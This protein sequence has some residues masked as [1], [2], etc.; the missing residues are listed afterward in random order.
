MDGWREG[1][2]EGW[3]EH[4]PCG[5]PVPCDREIQSPVFNPLK[6]DHHSHFTDN[7]TETG[8][9]KSLA[10]SC[11]AELRGRRSQGMGL[12]EARHTSSPFSQVATGRGS[13]VMDTSSLSLFPATTTI[14]FSEVFPEQSRWIFGGSSGKKEVLE[15]L[16]VGN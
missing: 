11:P 9:G 12:E 14:E 10:P 1:W 8:R 4:P 16:G 6:K 7:E 13:P 15:N 5:R 3:R 2:L